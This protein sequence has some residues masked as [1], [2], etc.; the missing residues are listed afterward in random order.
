MADHAS[1]TELVAHPVSSAGGDQDRE[2]PAAGGLRSVPSIRWL[3]LAGALVTVVSVYRLIESQWQLIPVAAQYLV[4]VVAA[5]GLFSVGEVTHGRLRLPLAGSALLLLF[6]ALIPVLS[7]GAVYLDLLAAPLGW[8]AFLVGTSA[9]LVAAR[10]PLRLILRYQGRLYPAIL[11]TFV[12]AQPLFPELARSRPELIDTIYLSAAIVLGLL[13]HL[14][15]R[16]INRFFFHRDRRDGVSRPVQWLPFCVLGALF[17][18]AML[19]LDPRS[20]LMA[21]PLAVIGIVLAATGEEYYR[22]LNQAQGVESPRWPG[23]SVAL[24]TVGIAAIV[25]ALPLSFGDP[26]LRCPALVSLCAAAFFLRWSVRSP[27]TGWH[28]AAVAS[29]LFAYHLSPALVPAL[30]KELW[31]RLLTLTGLA[32][33]SPLA[34]S[35]ADLGFLVG[36]V[37]WSRL[38]RRTGAS[39]P[40]RSVHA[41]ICVAYQWWL[42]GL[43]IADPV[44]PAA[45]LVVLTAVGLVG[46]LASRRREL[47]V[48][49][50]GTSSA[51]VLASSQW[52]LGTS[53][54]LC[55]PTLC[56]LGVG[57]LL[58]AVAGRALEPPLA[59]ALEIEEGAARHLLAVLAIVVATL[60]GGHGLLFEGLRS[61]IGGLELVLAGGL[62]VATGTRLRTDALPAVGGVTAAIGLQVVVFDLAGGVSPALVVM[63]QVLAAFLLWTLRS[64][65]AGYPGAPF[66]RPA[67]I[68]LACFHSLLALVWLVLGVAG[69]E[70]TI[71]PLILAILGLAAA[72]AGLAKRSAGDVMLGGLLVVVCAQVQLL[73]AVDSDRWEVTIPVSVAVAAAPLLVSLLVKR[74]GLRCRLLQH[75][76]LEP[77][78][79]NGLVVRSVQ[80][81]VST[82]SAAAVT[83]CLLF[84]G[85]AGLLL[86]VTAVAVTFF[87][88]RELQGQDLAAAAPMRLSLVLLLQALILVNDGSA[89][90]TIWALLVGG[91]DLL[92]S[93]ALAL[94][95]WRVLVELLGRNRSLWI[96][97]RT[98]ELVVGL[99]YL[100]SF[101]ADSAQPL[102]ATLWMTVAAVG[103]AAL[104]LRRSTLDLHPRSSWMGQLWAALTVLQLFS[105]GWLSLDGSVVAWVL[106]TY[107]V[108]EYGL[109]AALESTRLR[110]V[111]GPSSRRIGLVLP[112]A[113]WLAA[114]Y[115]LMVFGGGAPWLP[116]LPAFA[117]SLFYACVALRE[118]RSTVPGITAAATFSWTLM[119]VFA[120]AGLGVEFFSL[121]PGV[122]LMALAYLLGPRIGPVW[123]RH[124]ATSG[125]ACIYAT[126]I[127]AL[128]DQV[129]WVWLAVLLV[130]TVVFGSA[131]FVLQSRSLLTVSTAAMLTDLGF[132]V[133]KIGTTEPLLLWVV[134]L[135]F[136]LALM[137]C[138]GYL[139]YQ[140]EGLLQQVRVFGQEIRSW[141]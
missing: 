56:A 74:P 127:I 133:F 15:S 64:S 101:L 129:S 47:V 140:R 6:T 49:V 40:L 14:G 124:L 122:A 53:Q 57:S 17:V 75:Y 94:L 121:A 31:A 88:R 61:G 78:Q 81:I 87:A 62:L 123:S 83:T 54:M 29:T 113:A 128:T 34:L 132:F 46:I 30:A 137:T 38:L 37:A 35:I 33:G 28:L 55:A 130:M 4:L 108:A 106:L 45:Y 141:Y 115:R 117:V 112:A 85:Q 111:L 3:L 39:P 136:G 1:R 18:G 119:V 93:I 118:G 98:L 72:D 24:L 43:A 100:A 126:P 110:L 131:C 99:L 44:N 50:Y 66:L 70:L 84:C 97:S 114:M 19:L 13:F 91:L 90:M 65:R 89:T 96:W 82:W 20:N 23:R 77:A 71:E 9:L 12:L 11:A 7:W 134:G 52:A 32:H 104:H 68:G 69:G 120:E 2:V 125:A 16:H 80:R 73:A 41:A 86:A 138:A 105:S 27:T 102:P 36:L 135:V 107:A 10:R 103:L 21:L 116:A 109:A 8:H 48:G 79:F 95:G 51:L 58:F 26:S 59:R 5:L 22:A 25:A 76:R 139:E 60:V 92:P 67:A 63:T 42:A